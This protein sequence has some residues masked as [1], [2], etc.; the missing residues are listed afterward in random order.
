MRALALAVNAALIPPTVVGE[1]AL[2]PHKYKRRPNTRYLTVHCAQTDAKW[3]G[4]AA[5]VRGWHQRENGWVD[6]G[7]H[8]FI[9]RDGTI[10]QGRPR[11]AVGS[12]VKDHNHESLGICLAGGCDAQKREE[13][14]F[15]PEQWT[16]LRELLIWLKRLHP[17]AD[18]NGHRDF[19]GVQKYCPSFDVKSWLSENPLG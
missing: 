3:D 15:T 13:N 14:N 19:P 4:T 10:E 16:S 11:W 2:P 9:R 5:D 1:P 8:Y 18:I 17:N 6:I 7:Y 12:H